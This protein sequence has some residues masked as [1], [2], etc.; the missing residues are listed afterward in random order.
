M[1]YRALNCQVTVR[2]GVLYYRYCSAPVRYISLSISTMA[3]TQ[4]D[5]N[6]GTDY[7]VIFDRLYNINFKMTS[8]LA[9]YRD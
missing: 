2:Y 6:A 5:I 1:Y 8:V 7:F 4:K 3:E 9:Q